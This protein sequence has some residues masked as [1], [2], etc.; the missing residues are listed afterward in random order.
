MVVMSRAAWG[1]KD[2]GVSSFIGLDKEFGMGE[3]GKRFPGVFQQR[4]ALPLDTELSAG[5]GA[6]VGDDSFNSVFFF[7]TDDGGRRR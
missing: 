7:S 2:V 4:I 1:G 3:M 6:M 5:S